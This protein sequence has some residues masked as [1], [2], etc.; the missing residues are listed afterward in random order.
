MDDNGVP[1]T[2][3]ERLEIAK[4]IIAKALE[5]GIPKHRI[6]IDTLVLTASAE[7]ALVK[8][9]LE[10][11]RLVSALGVKTALG[12][13]NVSFGLPNRGLLNKVF[14]TMAMNSGLNMPIMNPLDEEMVN[15]IYAYNVLMNIDTNSEQYINKY[16]NIEAA[17]VATIANSL[18]LYDAVKKGL[19][20]DVKAL[21]IKELEFNDPMYIV[22]EILIKALQDVGSLYDKGKLFLPQ[23]ISSAEAAK[24]AFNVI[25]DKFPKSN[26]S[27]ATVVMATVKGDVH[28]I[29]KNI[30]KV[31]LES[32][33]YNVIDL[34]KDTPINA[35][36]GA[37]NKYKPLAIGLSALM[38][39]TV[40]S[41]EEAIKAL[42]E[43]NCE[44]KIFV[45]G[46]VITKEI[47]D[48]IDADYYSKDAL[49][50]VNILEGIIR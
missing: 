37:Y 32:Y 39:T 28:D 50:F 26:S 6:M 29:G 27:K 34:G 43:I 48:E 21:T 15:S 35:I 17:Q 19:K 2:A 18:T 22:N 10:G 3:I 47:A 33:G 13:S 14:L 8:E 7:Q 4:R 41:M 40:L 24:E 20:N 1:K 30:C 45:G 36:I 16:Q 46:A 5:Y 25:Q 31:V 49:E 11:L 42:R 12:V 23:L 9:T 44:S 38:T